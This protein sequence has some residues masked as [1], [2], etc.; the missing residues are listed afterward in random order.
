MA[1][2]EKADLI[3]SPNAP[4]RCTARSRR[5]GVHCRKSRRSRLVRLPDARRWQRLRLWSG[6]SAMKSESGHSREAMTLRKPVMSPR[7]IG[8]SGAQN[9][10]SRS[11]A[12]LQVGERNSGRHC[13]HLRFAASTARSGGQALARNIAG[14]NRMALDARSR[15]DRAGRQPQDRQPGVAHLPGHDPF[16][17]TEVAVYPVVAQGQSGAADFKRLSRCW[18]SLQIAAQSVNCQRAGGRVGGLARVSVWTVRYTGR[19]CF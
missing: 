15:L 8:R 11:V 1:A 19:A 13:T 16:G 14:F 17:A 7:R 12:P 10:R 2:L 6:T 9:R 18:R 4:P 5:S 3:S